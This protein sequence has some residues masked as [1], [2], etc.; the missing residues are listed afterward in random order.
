M[1]RGFFVHSA[2]RLVVYLSRLLGVPAWRQAACPGQR[3]CRIVEHEPV[4]HVEGAHDREHGRHD[5]DNGKA[6]DRSPA[7]FLGHGR[8]I[9]IGGNPERFPAKACPGLDPGWIPVRAKKTRQ[10]IELAPA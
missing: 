4:Q 7:E 9:L 1:G 2:V 6:C 3:I 5:H 8:L 10:N